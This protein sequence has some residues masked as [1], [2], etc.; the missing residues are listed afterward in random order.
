MESCDEPTPYLPSCLL[1][2]LDAHEP[3]EES[4][5][6]AHSQSNQLPVG[7]PL[8]M[9]LPGISLPG[10]LSGSLG[11]TLMLA[12]SLSGVPMSVGNVIVVPQMFGFQ[13]P[14]PT[15]SQ[16]DVMSVAMN[17]NQ[18]TRNMSAFD[19]GGRP[20]GYVPPPAK[21]TCRETHPQGPTATSSNST[22]YITRG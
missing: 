3:I 19:T 17:V 14:T 7:S 22:R 8:P 13:H 20:V 16:Y 1:N 5:S 11:P 2:E 18:S 15:M 4:F 6:L 21:K 9:S 12:G 10:S